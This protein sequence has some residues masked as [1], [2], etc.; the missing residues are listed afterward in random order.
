MITEQ[1][2]ENLPPVFDLM[3]DFQLNDEDIPNDQIMKVL[4]QIEK[5][6]KD[7]VPV[8]NQEI[9]EDQSN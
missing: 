3:P 7:L 6:N 8:A 5:E 9:Q 4:A 2:Q 1:N